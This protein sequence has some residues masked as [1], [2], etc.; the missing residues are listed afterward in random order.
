MVQAAGRVI[1]TEQDT[2]T[3]WLMDARYL[4]QRYRQL[5]PPWWRLQVTTSLDAVY[6]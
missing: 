1:R 6:R 3:V 4:E 2:G 5:L